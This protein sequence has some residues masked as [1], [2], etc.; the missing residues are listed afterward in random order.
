MTTEVREPSV[1]GMFYPGTAARLEAEVRDL[2]TVEKDQHELVACVAPHAGYVYSGGVA[3]RL[4]GHLRLPRR[5]VLLGPNHTGLGTRIAVAPHRA[6]RTPLGSLQVDRRLAA[7]LMDAHP[8]ASGDDAA[9]WR[10]H[11]LEV[12]LPFLQLHRPEI[13]V[14]PVCLA[15]LRRD[16][17]A[18]L[19][20]ALAAV[21]EAAGEPVGVIASSDMTHFEPEEQARLH[22]R[23][24]I[25][26]ALT[27]DPDMLYDTVHSNRISMCGVIPATVALVVARRL[28]ATEA[29]L[30][31]YATSADAGGD[32]SSVV[33]YAGICIHREE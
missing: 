5:V 21:I 19:G 23:L 9:H 7:A 20:E 10:E 16:E 1:A 13:M 8:E 30:V 29:H 2:L 24:A 32:R 3:G 28:G 18:R 15:H 6:W 26:A 31:D 4:Y 17:C 33:G 11:S 12:H 27:L 14:L 25:D 22:D